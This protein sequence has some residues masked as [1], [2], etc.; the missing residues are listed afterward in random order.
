M[1]CR[2]LGCWLL[3][4]VT[5]FGTHGSMQAADVTGLRV[6]TFRC[7]VT[8]PVDGRFRGGWGQ[9]L[10]R[11]ADPLW[12]KGI[13]LAEG[14]KRYVLCAVDW[15]VL[16]NETHLL[17]RRQLAEAAGTDVTRVAVQCVHQ[18]TAPI[19]DGDEQAVLD[20]SPHP[21][22]STDAR[23]AAEIAQRLAAAVRAA[24]PR[25]A[26]FDQVGT[27]ES[28]VERIAANR[29][30]LF[31]DG[32]IRVRWSA[33]TDPELQA[34]PEGLIDPLLK[35]ITLARGGQPL[36]RLHY[37]AVHAQ[38]AGGD[39]RVSGDFVG[40]AR[41][42]LEQQ[43]GVFQIYFSGCSGDVT[44]GKYNDG[45]DAVR[46]ELTDRLFAALEA[47]SRATQ[48]TPVTGI[49]WRTQDLVL[50]ARHDKG[51][52]RAE[53]QAVVADAQAAAAARCTAAGRVAFHQRAERPL[54]I[55][56][57]ELG[58]VRV[59]HLPGEPFVE[60]QLHAQQA[61]PSCFVAVAGYGDG[62]PGY[63]CTAKSYPEGGYEPTATMLAPAAETILKRAITGLLADTASREAP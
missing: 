48:Y 10:T 38:T 27:G 4:L 18:H 29:R 39:G 41:D 5:W 50:P 32:Q 63:L 44:A 54:A 61:A 62:G 9:P 3:V 59:L 31:P 20:Q 11:L 60:F 43:Q 51:Y 17:W 7:D 22:R 14:A 58:R 34:A 42:R 37:Y 2:S 13:V 47:A 52:E 26:P 15:C 6:A 24:L 16:C 12:A 40:F 23:A 33:C 45:T 56:V 1:I 57:L 46:A 19:V 28:R 30:V 55:S 8:P 21:P 36:V 25:L 49:G 35:T 53:N